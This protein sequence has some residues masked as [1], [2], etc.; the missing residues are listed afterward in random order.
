METGHRSAIEPLDLAWG[1][2]EIGTEIS[3]TE[4]QTF[5][6]LESGAIRSAKKINGQWCADRR[7]LRAEFRPSG[8][9]AA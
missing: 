9:E 2:R 3:R 8:S 7:A 5:H 4:R 6:L 1:A